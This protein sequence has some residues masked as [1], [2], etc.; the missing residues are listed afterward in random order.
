M[1]GGG[2]LLAQRCSAWIASVIDFYF[3]V[4]ADA[5]REETAVCAPAS[6]RPIADAAIAAWPSLDWLR[7]RRHTS[8]TRFEQASAVRACYSVAHVRTAWTAMDCIY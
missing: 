4:L 5:E 8:P 1:G 6:A 2:G 3:S 7:S